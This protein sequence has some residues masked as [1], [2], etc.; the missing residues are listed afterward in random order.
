LIT[1]FKTLCL[2]LPYTYIYM[3][4]AFAIALLLLLGVGGYFAY[5]FYKPG[6]SQVPLHIVTF[7]CDQGK[8]I[9]AVFYADKVDLTLSDGRKLTLPQV[10]AESG[11]RYANADNSFVFWSR[12]NTSSIGEGRNEPQKQSYTN[13]VTPGE[14]E[15]V[16]ATK[17]YSYPPLGFSIKYPAR[18][19]LNES[20]M[21]DGLGPEGIPGIKVSVSAAESEATNLSSDSGVS[22]EY[23]PNVED[24]S[25]SLFLFG[26]PAASTVEEGGTTYSVV[27]ISGAGAGNVYE[28][29]VYALAGQNPCIAVRYFIHYTQLANYPAGTKKA[30]EREQ[31]LAEFDSIRKSLTLKN[32]TPAEE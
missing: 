19:T 32:Q 9:G 4:Q 6:P 14:L 1:D 7:S 17:T 5:T 25:A 16:E 15:D 27:S 10:E 23:L 12:G 3:K 13:C 29:K 11:A 20:F 21:Y 26:N 2:K 30:F 22:V 24:C 18:Y 31:L 8:T 28:E